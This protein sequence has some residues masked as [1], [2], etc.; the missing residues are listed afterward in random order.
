MGRKYTIDF[1][2]SA[3]E[4]E[5]YTL[6]S[7]VYTGW[8][9]KLKY[10]CPKG[11]KHQIS[12]G[13]W[14]QN[15]R[16]PYCSNRI[17]KTIDGVR[18]QFESENYILTSTKYING[19]HKLSYI[20]PNGHEHSIIL[21]N[22]NKGIRCPYCSGKKRKSIADIR[23]LFTAEGY[24]L[25]TTQYK[26]KNTK[27]RYI[28]PNGHSGHTTWSS[29]N[30][31]CR[32]LQCSGNMRKTLEYAKSFFKMEGTV[33]LSDEYINCKTKLKCRCKEGH[34]FEASLDNWK[35]KKHRCPT[36]AIIKHTGPGNPC[37]KGGVS[38][39]PY[40]PVWKD[41]E[42]KESIKQRDGYKCLNPYCNSENP[43]DLN[44]HHINYNKKFCGPENLIT[45]CR[46]CNVAANKN[47]E[48]HE[49][50]YKAILYRR[51]KYK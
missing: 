30:Q 3:F 20:C 18:A 19:K 16:C 5:G 46:S 26:N 2:K 49:A 45:V 36:C 14:L 34:E 31:G 39:E 38:Y 25:L 32:C 12:F 51:Y 21:I 40:C 43:H 41:K 24:E 48:W 6:L 33:V 8:D 9:G 35:N 7:T 27:L 15:S 11:H 22:W 23:R 44:I 17:K 29:W 4:K 42:Y 28:C 50:W 47:R 13:K 37:W 10:I 1:V